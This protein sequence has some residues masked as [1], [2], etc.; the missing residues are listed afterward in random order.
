M[1]TSEIAEL[2]GGEL[3]GDGQI[4][5][6]SCASAEAAGDSQISFIEKN[7]IELA[8]SDA[9]CIIVPVDAPVNERRTV[10]RSVRPKLAFARVAAVLHPPKSRPAE[11][12]PSAVIAASATVGSKV[13]V[14][15]FVCI[16]E[17]S[18]IGDRVHLRAGSKIGDNVFIGEG[19]ILHPNV[20]VDDNCAVGK[21][22][23][24]HS[25]VVIGADGFGY[26]RDETGDHVKFPQIGTVVIEDDVE[27]G[28]STCIDRGA[29]GET[30]IGAGTKIDNLVQVGHN[31]HIG[32]RCVIAAQTGISGSVTI[33]DDCVIG[34]QVGFGDHVYVRSG[35]VIGSQAGVLPGKIVRPG[36]W[37]GTPIQPLEQ[38]KRQ[39][40]HVKGLERLKTEVKELRELLR[41]RA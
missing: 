10:I 27:I 20:F 11:I 28:A 8:S 5:I 7:D 4:E 36:V 21:N 37:W 41:S 15:A 13:F 14:G 23:I 6:F 38:Y 39:N 1:K 22:V 34:G 31:V 9:A 19:S 17:N 24:L 3:H 32:R 33:E 25:G 40:A 2:V 26:V 29:L 30:R 18:K 16:G 35:A 12:H